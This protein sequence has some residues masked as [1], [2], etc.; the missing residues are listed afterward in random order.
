MSIYAILM[1]YAGLV[2]WFAYEVYRAPL[3][4]NQE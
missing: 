4:E 3:I 1:I 2:A